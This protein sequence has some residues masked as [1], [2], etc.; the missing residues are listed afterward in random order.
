MRECILRSF[1]FGLSA[2][3]G[4]PMIAPTAFLWLSDMKSF[5]KTCKV[6][7]FMERKRRF[8]TPSEKE[9]GYDSVYNIIK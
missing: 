3:G 8:S 5:E 1:F 4:L 6:N 7:D 9:A 2:M